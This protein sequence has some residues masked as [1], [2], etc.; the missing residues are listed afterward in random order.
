MSGFYAFQLPT[1]STMVKPVKCWTK[2][3]HYDVSCH[4]PL[5]ALPGS[6]PNDGAFTPGFPVYW[7]VVVS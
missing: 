6:R 1:I 7:A 3:A 2:T 4:Q 5:A